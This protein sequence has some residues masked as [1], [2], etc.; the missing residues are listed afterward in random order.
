MRLK[1]PAQPL[2]FRFSGVSPLCGAVAK[3]YE[4]YP[5]VE[6][7]L[8]LYRENYFL[9]V[10]SSLEKRVRVF[11]AASEYGAF[12]GPGSVL[13]SYYEEHGRRIS[14]NAVAELGAALHGGGK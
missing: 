2:V 6:A 11:R 12:L 4:I 8:C 5:G 9:A 7:S 1:T 13:Y 14:C 3:L 10:H